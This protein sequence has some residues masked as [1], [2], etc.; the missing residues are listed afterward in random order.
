MNY[1][2]VQNIVSIS[3]EVF[4]ICLNDLMINDLV[5]NIQRNTYKECSYGIRPLGLRC[6]KY[7]NNSK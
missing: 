6:I 5:L 2:K 4:D 7:I 1:K 3:N